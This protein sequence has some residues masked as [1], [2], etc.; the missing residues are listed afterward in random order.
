MN[1]WH[2]GLQAFP[3]ALTSSPIRWASSR[4]KLSLPEHVS[5]D[6]DE[7]VYVRCVRQI[8]GGEDERLRETTGLA[9]VLLSMLANFFEDLSVRVG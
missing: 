7:I 9:L 3:L 4:P 2:D 6:V 8:V 5:S 1:P